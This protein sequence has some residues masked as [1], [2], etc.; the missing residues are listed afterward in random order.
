VLNRWKILF[1]AAGGDADSG[2]GRG[3]ERGKPIGSAFVSFVTFGAH[4]SNVFSDCKGCESQRFRR[5]FGEMA[6]ASPFR[7]F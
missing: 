4:S 6:K 2:Q 3:P 7:A 5:E 1:S